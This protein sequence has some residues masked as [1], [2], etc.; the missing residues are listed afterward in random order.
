MLSLTLRSLDHSAE[1]AP[2]TVLHDDI[3]LCVVSVDD[4]VIVPRDVGVSEVSQDVDLARRREAIRKNGG[5]KQRIE[6][7]GYEST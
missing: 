3:D 1:I 2:R 5:K 7:G 6:K 4:P